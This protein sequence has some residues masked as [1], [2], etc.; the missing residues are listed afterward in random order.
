MFSTTKYNSISEEKDYLSETLFNKLHKYFYTFLIR[1][2][3]SQS[4][5]PFFCLKLLVKII[6]NNITDKLKEK[7]SSFLFYILEDLF[8]I[9]N[10]QANITPIINDMLDNTLTRK[11]DFYIILNYSN[12]LIHINNHSDSIKNLQI[13]SQENR[14]I[15]CGEILFYKTI[16]E[17]FYEDK[18][19]I[20]I[21]NIN[22]SISLIKNNKENFYLFILDFILNNGFF[23]DFKD[24]LNCINLN[25]VNLNL[26]NEKKFNFY[27]NNFDFNINKF[28]TENELLKNKI[29]KINNLL[30]NQNFFNF[31][32]SEKLLELIENYYNEFHDEINEKETIKSEKIIDYFLFIDEKL[33]LDYLIFITDYFFFQ[34]FN[35]EIYEI[36]MF[37]LSSI[38]NKINKG[39]KI[40]SNEKLFKKFQYQILKFYQ[41]LILNVLKVKIKNNI[42]KL[43]K[44]KKRKNNNKIN[45]EL[46]IFKIEKI[47]NVINLTKK[48]ISGKILFSLTNELKN[49]IISNNFIIFLNKYIS[50]FEKE[51][52]QN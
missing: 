16:F 51:L 4:I 12:F 45:F 13:F 42:K 33:I 11:A 46:E 22:K 40:F 9:D 32:L 26:I 7:C 38:D 36:L 18:K 10:F 43:I 44:Y 39:N 24:V 14:F 8:L 6:H 1:E 31:K 20:F 5:N 52:N 35:N 17:Y 27:K 49:E 21:N 50:H 29:Y 47:I 34:I 25:I 28:C 30:K 2:Y 41:I 3:Y 15:N 37:F 23:N 48:I 19:N